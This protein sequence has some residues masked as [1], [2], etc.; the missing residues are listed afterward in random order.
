M[1]RQLLAICSVAALTC[2]AANAAP[3]TE[4]VPP[5][6]LTDPKSIASQPLAGAAPVPIA[7]LFYTRSSLDATWLPH[8]NAFVM[9]TNL[10]GRF[11]LWIVP[12]DGGF[13]L[14]LT[15]SDDRQSG[16]TAS[17]DGKWVVFQSDQGGGEIYDLYAVPASGGAVVNLTNT[18]DVD[19]Q[20]AVFSPDG[21]MLAFVQRPKSAST[22]NIA[23]MDFA[24]RRVR[25]LTHEATKDH[26]W[27]FAAFSR[28]GKTIF[29]NRTN[30]TFT[31]GEIWSI[32]VASGRATRLTPE[33]ARNLA[34]DASADGQTLA[35][36]MENASGIQQAALFDLRSKVLHPLKPDAWEQ[37]SLHFS[38][39][40]RMLLFS[41][42]VDGKT[43]LEGYDI[44]SGT[45]KPLDLPDGVN[46][47][48]SQS[49]SSFTPDG[50]HLL[51]S[52]QASNT[53]IDYW[54]VDMQSGT[55]RQITR[56][57]LASIDPARLPKAE[58]VH[59]KS[60]DG[61][62]IS[63]LL[64]VP[65]NLARDSKAPGVVLPHGGP[66]GQTVDSFNRT[67][68]ALASRGFVAI[69][70]NVRGSTGYG[71]AFEQANRKDL[72]GRDLEDEIAGAKFLVDTGYVDAKKVGITGGSYGG[73]MTLMA[74]AKAPNLWAAAVEQYGII[75]WQQMLLHESPVLQ[76]YEKG[77][78]GDP[79]KDKDVYTA[80]SPLT[81][82]KNATAPLL[83][84]QG[85]ND[86]RVPKDQAE[87]VIA[88]LKA[89]GRTVDA[90]FYPG[91][92]HGFYKR[93]D[94]IDAMER[95]VAWMEKYLK[96]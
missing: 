25:Q 61:T 41:S 17:P 89:N 22:P 19:E 51:V 36:T 38:P 55:G 20:G 96:H 8:A 70:P 34:S 78:L 95:T 66:T 24:S 28:D 12:A 63:A 81:Y 71:R 21:R 60:A 76:E 65:F 87:K 56:L 47:E 15:Q 83:V 31:E 84:L 91:E 67:A 73:Y 93:E 23:V 33:H 69:A 72:G 32:N 92:G 39:D 27:N 48:A 53:P 75:D 5:R 16:M 43:M 57:G 35:I 18:A 68:V 52:H 11:N 44:A 54:I 10:T 4:G 90:H 59:Y 6:D 46:S 45:A 9:S 85:D 14:Q 49:E 79:V 2:L 3:V 77:L 26:F 50:R 29:A 13:P 30:A 42:N 40:G 64:W 86:I 58:I 94:Q 62:I 1:K 80:S 74:I 37:S 7:D 82:M 88:V